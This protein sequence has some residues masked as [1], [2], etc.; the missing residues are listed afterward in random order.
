[1]PY[2]ESADFQAAFS[3]TP[4]MPAQRNAQGQLVP[5]RTMIEVTFTLHGQHA[6]PFSR[7]RRGSLNSSYWQVPGADTVVVCA[8]CVAAEVAS[9]AATLM[10]YMRQE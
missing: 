1:M 8:Q 3:T 9:E 6:A 2:L 4:L 7:E 5:G 10:W